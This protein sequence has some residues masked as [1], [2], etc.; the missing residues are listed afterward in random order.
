MAKIEQQPS[1]DSKF[2]D[3][4][5]KIKLQKATR[6]NE[7]NAQLNIGFA[8]AIKYKLEPFYDS[9]SKGSQYNRSEF[10]S[11][12]KEKIVKNFYDTE[13]VEDI[14]VFIKQLSEAGLNKIIELIEHGHREFFK[15]ILD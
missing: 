8:I 13:Q 11:N 6:L 15:D 7:T 4:D 5:V 3:S 10:I 1:I 14:A 12:D 2:G 9:D